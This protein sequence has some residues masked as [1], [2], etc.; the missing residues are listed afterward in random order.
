MI[1]LRTKLIA[2]N[3]VTIGSTVIV[4]LGL[5]VYGLKS[6]SD[7]FLGLSAERT[8]NVRAEISGVSKSNIENIRTIYEVEAKKKG[9]ALLSKDASTIQPMVDDN[10]FGAVREF[11]EKTFSGDSDLLSASFFVLEDGDIRGWQVVN[12]SNPKGFEIPI[13]YSRTARAWKAKT[14]SGKAVT[15]FDPGVLQAVQANGASIELKQEKVPGTDGVEFDRSYFECVIPVFKGQFGAAVAT[16]RKAGEA[17]GFLRYQISLEAMEK[18]IRKQS[19]ANAAMIAKLEEGNASAQSRTQELGSVQQ[20][21]MLV[22]TFGTAGIFVFLTIVASTIFSGKITNPVKALTAIAQKMAKGDY[23]QQVNVS[24]GDEI[25]IL[26]DAFREMSGAIRKRDEDLA[27]INKNLE[28][29]VEERTVQLKAELKNIASL[30]NNMKQAVFQVDPSGTVVAPASK[31]AESLFGRAIVGTRVLDVVFKDVDPASEAFGGLKTAM[32]AVFGEDALQWDLMEDQFPNR[33][34][35]KGS[36][37]EKILKLSYHPIFDDEDKVER[38]MLVVSDVTQVEKL[39]REINEEKA[40]NGKRNQLIEDLASIRPDQVQ[41][42]FSGVTRL[43]NDSWS[44]VDKLA[45]SPEARVPLLRAIHTVKGNSRVFKMSLIASTTHEAENEILRVLND[46][47]VSLDHKIESVEAAISRIQA[48]ALEYA[49]MARVIFRSPVEYESEF[50]TKLNAEFTNL[51]HALSLSGDTERL[52]EA[53]KSMRRVAHI[54]GAIHEQG[55]ESE[56]L[57]FS[58]TL[59]EGVA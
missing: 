7:S 46:E 56:L 57:E 47:S 42:Y 54:L 33:V 48:I 1:T 39:E 24:S 53:E 4:L 12:R 13:E 37:E 15:V 3:V 18:Q 30:L 26:A 6:L 45:S 34:V 52:R 31:F 51:D 5:S 2:S 8:E 20:Q 40:K 19:E 38:V 22:L 44:E 49:A 32:A 21:K 58:R 25:G 9:Q 29:T 11:I 41:E 23:K 17:I 35:W 55:V 27:E 28:K 43:F 50:L 14:K 10:S 59:S 16:A 36:K